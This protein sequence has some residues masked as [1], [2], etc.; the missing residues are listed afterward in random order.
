MAAQASNEAHMEGLLSIFKSGEYSD[1]TIICGSDTYKVHR[2][3]IC[4]R[5]TFFASAC[6]GK[7]KESKDSELT[8]NDNDRFAVGAMLSYL[9]SFD[10]VPASEVE[11]HPVLLHARVYIVADEFNI[12]A[13]KMLAK[14]KFETLVELDWNNEAF[15]LAIKDI[16]TLSANDRGLRN[17][18]LK[19]A[20]EHVQALRDRGEFNAMLRDEPDFTMELLDEV[21]KGRNEEGSATMPT[22]KAGVNDE[23]WSTEYCGECGEMGPWMYTTNGAATICRSCG[24]RYYL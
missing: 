4:P 10:Y 23:P 11:I 8:L 14:E 18:V 13:L 16:Y 20:C 21:L 3:V 7:F 12:P 17:V 6:N 9:Y 19:V 2:A 5:S 22:Q 24:Y 1:F 15:S